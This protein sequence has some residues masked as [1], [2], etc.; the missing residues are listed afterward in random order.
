[1]EY[2]GLLKRFAGF[3]L[4]WETTVSSVAP[5]LLAGR[6][7]STSLLEDLQ[8]LGTTKTDLRDIAVC[9]DLP[10]L[11]SSPR[12]LGSQYVLEGATLGGQ[13]LNRHFV[14]KFGFNGQGCLFFSGYGGRTAS[15][16]KQFG[17]TIEQLTPENSDT[18]VNSAIMT[19]ECMHSWLC[20]RAGV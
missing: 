9:Q 8:Y 3:Y 14:Q 6:S 1:M 4:P 13:I 7:K 20:L 17:A 15:M 10:S 19:F 11:D 5:N 2:R 12:I 16:W 18:A